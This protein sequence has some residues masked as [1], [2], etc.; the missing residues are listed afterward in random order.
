VLLNF[1]PLYEHL[2][3]HNSGKVW[4]AVVF[5]LAASV[6]YAWLKT[7]RRFVQGVQECS[8]ELKL[9]LYDRVKKME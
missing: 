6:L 4:A 7:Y 9:E 8:A 3:P 5:A 1:F 2:L